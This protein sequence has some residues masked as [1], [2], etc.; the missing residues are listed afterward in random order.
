VCNDKATL[1]YIVNLESVDIHPWTSRISSPTSPD[2]IVIDLDPSD[3]DFNKVIK[4]AQAA[5]KVFDTHKIKSFVKTSGKT[6]L[7]L[8]LPCIDI[9]FG[10]SRKIAQH[11][12]D[13]IHNIVP[14]ITT[15]NVSVNS[16]ANLLYLDPNQNDYADRMAAAYYVRAYH[17]PTV[18]IPLDWKEVNS[19]LNPGEFTIHNIAARLEKQGDLFKNILNEKVRSA[20]SK[21]LKRFL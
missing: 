6:G 16:R 9:P 21:I 15:T 3:D 11:L 14:K 5:K 19:K 7:H 17:S 2:Y 18:S 1:V 10:D 20:N 13:N 4:T 8:L 12:C